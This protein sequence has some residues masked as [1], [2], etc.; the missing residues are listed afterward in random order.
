MSLIP[1]SGKDL[2]YLKS[3]RPVTLLATDYKILAKALATRLQKVIS[4]LVNHDQV[5]YIK[6]RYI[7]ENVRIIDDMMIYTSKK[8]IPGFMVLIDY[9]KAFDTVEWDFL[10]KT[11]NAFNFGAP[12]TN[13]IRLLYNNISS[14]TINNGYLSR[15]FNLNRGIRQGCPISAL[16]FV[17][18]AEILSIKLRSDKNVMGIVVN[19]TEYKICQLADDTTIFIKN[20]NCL[21]YAISL[22]QKFQVCSGLKL[23]LEKT[24]I[25]PLGPHRLSPVKLPNVVDKLSINYGAF[26]TL[27]VWFSQNFDDAMKLNYEER[28][29]KIETL[30]QIWKQRSLSWKGRIM[31][32]K[33]LILSQVTHLLSMIFTPTRILEK[34]DKLLFKFLWH[35]KPARVKRETIIAETCDGGLKMPDVFAFHNAQKAMWIKRY[36]HNDTGKWKV[37]F[38]QLSHLNENEFDHKLSKNDLKCKS[39][40]HYQVLDC[41]FQIKS[42]PPN[43][44]NEILNEY[45]FL[46]KYIQ[47]DNKSILPSHLGLQSTASV[48]DLK[49]NDLLNVNGKFMLP[50]DLKEKKNWKISILRINS[51]LSA[52]PRTWIA[53]IEKSNFIYKEIPRATIMV[54]KCVKQISKLLSADIYWDLITKVTKPPTAISTWMDLFPFLEQVNWKYLFICVNKVTSEPYLQTFQYKIL[55][56]T[57]NCNYNLFKW[58]ILEHCMCH[59][60]PL[61]IDTIEHHLYYCPESKMFW[62]NIENWLESTIKIKFSFTICEVIFGMLD[63]DVNIRHSVNYILLLGKWYINLAKTNDKRIFY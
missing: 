20:L 42:N 12:F 63:L 17:L 53:K 58:N 40:F 24:E 51:L 4:D 7:G 19:N 15:N 21:Q 33:T 5:G 26:K 43:N 59:Y 6:G 16:L 18:V 61:E 22:F 3:W 28:F 44:V 1:K 55:N 47:I 45:V 8:S 49:I 14:C 11:L 38:Q 41:W 30:F 27:G 39:K 25:I 2:R 57:L 23:N 32:I 50:N 60:C 13:W 29:V 9:E 52:I 56:R 48:L 36:C 35:D 34:L 46:N 37:L 31:I 10:F 54:R 62:E